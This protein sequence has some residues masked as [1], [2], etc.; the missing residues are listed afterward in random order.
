LT[1]STFLSGEVEG[2]GNVVSC[3]KEGPAGG[4]DRWQK[5]W[6]SG[7]LGVEVGVV[8][9]VEFEIQTRRERTAKNVEEIS[10]DAS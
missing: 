1:A 3:E 5:V 8:G 9:P 2:S 6:W 4:L 7:P 10:D